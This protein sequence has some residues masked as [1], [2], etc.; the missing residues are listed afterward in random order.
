MQGSASFGAGQ[1]HE[2]RAAYELLMRAQ[3]VPA[4]LQ[5]ATGMCVCVCV[6]EM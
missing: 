3:E 6:F 5:R 2:V 4:S 1:E